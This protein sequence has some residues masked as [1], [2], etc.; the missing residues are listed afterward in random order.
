MTSQDHRDGLIYKQ[1]VGDGVQAAQDTVSFLAD[2][3]R[4]RE[5]LI[6]MQAERDPTRLS[7]FWDTAVVSYARVFNKGVRSPF[8]RDDILSNLSAASRQL[9]QTILVER[10]KHVAHSVNWQE[11]SFLAYTLTDPESTGRREFV[12]VLSIS[13][14][15][16]PQ[17]SAVATGFIQLVD[18]LIEIFSAEVERCAK[19]IKDQLK[20]MPLDVLYAGKPLTVQGGATDP[21]RPRR[22]QN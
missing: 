15:R 5:C 4:A 21:M 20:S 11:Q 2:L 1:V 18:E 19:E 16:M 14:R 12:D 10:D 13:M 7:I 6:F 9:H 22:R 17:T 3:K 8:P